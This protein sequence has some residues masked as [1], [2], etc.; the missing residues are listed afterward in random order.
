MYPFLGT[1]DVWRIFHKAGLFDD[2][3]ISKINNSQKWTVELAQQ[4]LNFLQQ[5]SFYFTNVVKWTGAD[6]TLPNAAKIKLFLPILEKEIELVQP[7]NIVTFGLLPFEAITQQKIKLADYYS[8]AM[9]TN[10]LKL[11]HAGESKVIPCYFPVGRG[12]PK[13][14]IELLKLL[15]TP[16]RDGQT[17]Q[18]E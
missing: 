11:F 16:C 17:Q 5:K 18:T 8:E 12:N 7:E 13:R 3:L 15:N 1:K 14:A 9:K 10:Q 2:M 6:G 4:V